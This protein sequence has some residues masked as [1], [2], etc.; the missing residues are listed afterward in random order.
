MLVLVIVISITITITIARQSGP[1]ARFVVLTYADSTLDARH[2]WLFG[3]V[4]IVTQ[5]SLQSTTYN[6]T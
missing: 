4:L 3:R 6:T 5:L 1:P 2:C